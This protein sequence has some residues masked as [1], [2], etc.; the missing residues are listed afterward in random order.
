MEVLLQLQKTNRTNLIEDFGHISLQQLGD[1][2]L[3][4]GQFKGNTYAMI[5]DMEPEYC[6]WI[7]KNI[8]KDKSALSLFR[9]YLKKRVKVALEDE[10]TSLNVEEEDFDF[11]TE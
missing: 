7:I 3:Q 10:T 6:H 8:K 1:F 5:V 4:V 2:V 11:D 9:H